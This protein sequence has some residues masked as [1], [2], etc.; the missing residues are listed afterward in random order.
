MTVIGF[1]KLGITGIEIDPVAIRLGEIEIRWYGILILLG[2]LT[3]VFFG[4]RKMKNFNH[5]VD[6]M[7]DLL[8]ITVPSAIIGCRL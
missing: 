1:P 7:L 2:L 6:D 3:A 4:M 5:T 8:I